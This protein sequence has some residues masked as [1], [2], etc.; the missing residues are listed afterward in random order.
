MEKGRWEE[1]GKKGKRKD[2]KER[3]RDQ[4]KSTRKDNFNINL[5][6]CP[7]PNS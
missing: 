5:L 3:E 4:W 6:G 1:N 2:R 7:L